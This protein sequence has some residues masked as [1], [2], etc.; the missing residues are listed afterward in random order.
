[1]NTVAW[2]FIFI[3]VIIVR[4]VAKGRA[5]NIPG[6]LGDA[7]QAL[8]AG[9]YDNFAEALNRSGDTATVSQ[10]EVVGTS[11][12]NALGGEV[13]GV[14]SETQKQVNG[15]IGYW[16]VK[17]GEA[18]KGYRFGSTGP[19]YYDCSGLMYRA[20][21]KVGYKGPRFFTG[22]VAAMPGMKRIASPNLG[23]SQVTRGDLVVWPGH[24]MGVVTS[25]GRFYSARSV[26]SGI[27]EAPI[28]GFRKGDPIY[29]RFGPP[30][31]R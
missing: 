19:D 25:P 22:T 2:A 23:V 13:A 17:L 5:T 16:A 12:A 10:G 18:A 21:Q 8:V 6:D 26:K 27:G 15:T 9:D 24:H 30:D 31:G 7:F 14:L 20:C 4:A 11:V 1:M 3:G 28:K 29:L